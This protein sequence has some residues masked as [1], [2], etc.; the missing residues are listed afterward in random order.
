MSGTS[1]VSEWHFV[2]Y[3]PSLPP[4]FPCSLHSDKCHRSGRGCEICG[5]QPRACFV[6]GGQLGW[7][8]SGWKQSGQKQSVRKQNR[9]MEGSTS[10]D[11]YTMD[12]R[13]PCCI[14]W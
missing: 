9:Q 10:S 7:N 14:Y 1:I 13:S 4:H 8:Q 5:R 2:S 11:E 6:H 12:C 3:C